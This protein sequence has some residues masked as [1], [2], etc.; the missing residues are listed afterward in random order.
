MIDV[1][2]ESQSRC[3]VKSNPNNLL[4]LQKLNLL[5]Y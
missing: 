5:V 1:N 3:L 2:V 4:L